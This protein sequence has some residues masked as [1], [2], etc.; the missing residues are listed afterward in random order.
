[1]TPGLST[2]FRHE[3]RKKQKTGAVPAASHC[4]A[5]S[6]C[7]GPEKKREDNPL[8]FV[9]LFAGERNFRLLFTKI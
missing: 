2:D 1:M 8:L 6:V 9:H 5:V 3:K 7:C 4:D